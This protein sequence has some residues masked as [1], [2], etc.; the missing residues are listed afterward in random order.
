MFG[1]SVLEVTLLQ[2]VAVLKLM[3]WKGAAPNLKGWSGCQGQAK[4]SPFLTDKEML[5]WKERQ[6]SEMAQ[7]T[8]SG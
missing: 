5:V 4:P 1:N 2:N 3:S 6:F 8:L 7:K